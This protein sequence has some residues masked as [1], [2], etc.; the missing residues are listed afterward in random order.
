MITEFS[1]F[2]VGSLRNVY[3]SLNADANTL[4]SYYTNPDSANN[5]FK[6]GF[7]PNFYILGDYL[8]GDIALCTRPEESDPNEEC[9]YEVKETGYDDWASE[10]LTTQTDLATEADELGT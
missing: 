10:I 5:Y 6:V 2:V 1:S 4:F 7:T 8:V 9:L 3:G